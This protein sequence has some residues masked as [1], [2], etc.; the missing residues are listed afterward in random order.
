MILE[1][2]CYFGHDENMNENFNN[3]TNFKIKSV[4]RFPYE[5]NDKIFLIRRI[6]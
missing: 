5:Q 4:S 6:F 2:R 1:K 3:V